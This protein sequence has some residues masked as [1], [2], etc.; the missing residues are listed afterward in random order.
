MTGVTFRNTAN[1]TTQSFPVASRLPFQGSAGDGS[2][3]IAFTP[4]TASS[5]VIFNVR[6]GGNGANGSTGVLV[7]PATAGKAGADGPLV[8][9]T[10][11]P[12]AI[13]AVPNPRRHHHRQHRRQW[14]QWRQFLSEHCRRRQGRRRGG[15]GRYGQRDVQSGVTINYIGRQLVY[16]IFVQSAAGSGGDGGSGY[17]TTGGGGG[18]G[19]AAPGGPV[20]LNSGANGQHHRR[21]RD[22]HLRPIGRRQRRQRRQQLRLG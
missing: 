16:G 5:N 19:G 13:T 8:S 9:Q 17:V 11:A 15:R 6:K 18:G 10:V 20:T 3:A 12:I 14:R 1:G 21:G 7:F 4:P 22:R 2:T